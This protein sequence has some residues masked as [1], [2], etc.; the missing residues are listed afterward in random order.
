MNLIGLAAAL[1]SGLIYALMALGVLISFRILDFPDLTADGSFPLGGAVTA[2]SIVAGINPWFA[3]I[4]GMMA[5]MMAGVITAWLHIKLGVLQLLAGILTMT[6][7]WSVNLRI[8]NSPNISLL[9]QP[10][11]FQTMTDFGVWGN[12][13]LLAMIVLVV[14]LILDWFFGTQM[15]LSMRATGSNAKM[16]QA[17]GINTGRMT[18]V[19]MAI[20]NGL[21]ALAGSLFVQTQAFSDVSIGI[22]T[23]VI[24][25]VAVIMGEAIISAKRIF[26]LTLSVILGSVLYR[27]F[28]QLALSSDVLRDIGFKS[29]DLNL[30]TAVLVVILLVVSAQ[31]NKLFAKRKVV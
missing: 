28:I 31:K 12:V 29:Q 9:G 3:C 7:L 26:W 20:S 1:E 25:L 19:G 27:F 8:M 15:G 13:I 2:V 6:A 14:K 11:I 21:V 5:G 24:G 30:V 23:I 18:I 4:F 17:Q 16:A 10:T 22:G